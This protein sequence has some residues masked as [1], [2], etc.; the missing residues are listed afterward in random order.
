MT[1]VLECPDV[2]PIDRID[3]E[4]GSKPQERK[5][6]PLSTQDDAVSPWPAFNATID[7]TLWFL[8]MRQIPGSKIDVLAHDPKTAGPDASVVD[9]SLNANVTAQVPYVTA[10]FAGTLSRTVTLRQY[11]GRVDVQTY[12]AIVASEQ[13]QQKPFQTA[14]KIN[15]LRKLFGSEFIV[16]DGLSGRLLGLNQQG[17]DGYAQ[18]ITAGVGTVARCR[19]ALKRIRTNNQ[20]LDNLFFIVNH[21]VYWDLV[22]DAETKSGTVPIEFKGN[23]VFNIPFPVLHY[24]GV[25]FCINNSS[26]VP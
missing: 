14:A 21:D 25:P 26:P 15:A 19:E 18:T 17:T 16:G 12:A 4:S 1:K 5:P 24:S 2:L 6:R 20:R 23:R 11:S 22:A 9:L 13:I 8:S 7:Q 10:A 3:S